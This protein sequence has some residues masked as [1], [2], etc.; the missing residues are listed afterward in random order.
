MQEMLSHLNR[1]TKIKQFQLPCPRVFWYFQWSSKRLARKRPPANWQTIKKKK[2]NVSNLDFFD[3]FV[4]IFQLIRRRA[5]HY[6]IVA[7]L[8]AKWKTHVLSRQVWQVFTCLLSQLSWASSAQ[9]W[10]VSNVTEDTL[11]RRSSRKKF[12][13]KYKMS[14][15]TF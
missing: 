14:I 12:I 1:T 10:H 13:L 11:A 4:I 3:W 8:Q 15:I 7:V 2:K 6:H 9:M 5:F